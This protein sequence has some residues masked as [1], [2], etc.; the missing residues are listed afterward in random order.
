MHG[1]S[2]DDIGLTSYQEALNIQQHCHQE[3]LLGHP[4]KILLL[5]HPPTITLGKNASKEYML[6]P[7]STLTHLGIHIEYTS[8]GGQITAHMPGQLIVY[9]I[10][11][12]AKKRL[13]IK[14]YVY[15]LEEIMIQSLSHYNIHGKRHQKHPGIWVF[16]QKI[17]SLG[18]RIRQ[19]VST[20]GFSLNVEN[21]LSIFSHI[22]PC[23]IKGCSMTSVQQLLRAKS[24]S[25][26]S[27]Q[28]R[29][30]QQ[31]LESELLSSG[32][33]HKQ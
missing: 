2:I 20:H 19:R 33:T 22:I 30:E 28:K 3:V 29:V 31:L 4:G 14:N 11:P 6:T 13:S 24:P 8:R 21:D 17:A 15:L 1:V 5:Q 23:G 7:E 9:L 32:R 10:L 26:A 25:F 27:V 16:H 12:I 18:L